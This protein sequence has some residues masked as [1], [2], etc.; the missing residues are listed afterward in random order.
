VLAPWCV[1]VILIL[2]RDARAQEAAPPAPAPGDSAAVVADADSGAAVPD[3]T[4]NADTSTPVTD[5]GVTPPPDGT[6]TGPAPLPLTPP[7]APDAPT[8]LRDLNAW[9]AYKIHAHLL[10][11]PDEARLFYRRGLMLHASGGNKEAFQLVRG[12]I[13]LDPGLMAPRLTLVAWLAFRQPA[14]ALDQIN[15]VIRL[16]RDS[17]M[18]QIVMA[19]NALYLF[20]QALVLALVVIAIV[21]LALNHAR[22]RHGWIE[23]LSSFAT[24][25]TA[26]WWSWAILLGPYLAGLGPA[27]PTLAFLGLLLPTARLRERSLF[28]LLA[29]TLAG[30]PFMTAALDRLSSPLHEDRAPFYGVP[31]LQTE[32]YTPALRAETEAAVVA[33][34]DNPFLH[35]AAGWMAQRAGDAVGAEAHY[36]R[37]LA[38][39]PDDDRTYN[40]LGN[41]LASQGR[42]DDALAAYRKA[43]EL[44]PSNLDAH[45]NASQIYTMRY[46]FHSANDELS[47]ASAI[48]FEVVK[49]LQ[50][51]RAES[52]W[53]GL[54]DQW[55]GP[56]TFWRALRQVPVRT[57]ASGALPPLWR[58][59]VECSGWTFSLLAF[60]VAAASLGLG[61]LFHRSVP[62]RDCGN[63][64]RPVC[65][66]CAQRR[67]E[68]ALCPDCAAIWSR[69]ESP[70]FGRVLLFQHRRRLLER[71]D[72][73]FR[74]AGTLAPGVGYLP[75][76]KLLRPLL[77]L[78]AGCAL[79]S[80]TVGVAAPFSYEPRFGVPGHDVPMLG[81]GLLWLAYYA[82]SIPIFVAFER[83]ASREAQ[84]PA[85]PIRRRVRAAASV[86]PPAVDSQDAA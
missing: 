6:S 33:H 48:D 18:I 47:R 24:P 70:E 21:V 85:A 49:D 26:R 19:T 38:A 36:R 58:T 1:A 15:D 27:L 23:R 39:W 51:D 31:E 41:T 54:V 61:L 86:N 67:R 62:V 52:K 46:D 30:V 57:T 69:A 53:A 56:R 40:N 50:A 82:I 65:R 81:L 83:R 10:A 8:S 63:C 9:I 43:I 25:A 76:R 4:Q 37:A 78:S 73:V 11:L 66:R 12:A 60:V 3:T 74:V 84:E 75:Y 44:N 71:R 79:A 20:I 29:L 77:F 45:F 55:I 13:K 16:A 35:F 22:L 14:E 42:S 32:P 2:S 72:T 64:G 34:P 17:F 68:L 28:V 7:S 80:A 59:R 5:T